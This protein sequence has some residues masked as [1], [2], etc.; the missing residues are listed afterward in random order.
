MAKQ[1][2]VPVRMDKETA[3]KLDH[4][5]KAAGGNRSEVIRSLIQAAGSPGD[6]QPQREKVAAG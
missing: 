6:R 3:S 5:V 1:F 4:L 2:Y